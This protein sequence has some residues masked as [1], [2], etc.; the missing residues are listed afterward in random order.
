MKVNNLLYAAGEDL[1][2]T[3]CTELTFTEPIDSEALKAAVNEALK[4]FAYFAVRLVRRGEEY[5]FE[6]NSAELAVTHGRVGAALGSAENEGY[7]DAE[8]DIERYADFRRER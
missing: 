7:G 8:H 2:N 3:I 1:V 6:P 4:R 5:V